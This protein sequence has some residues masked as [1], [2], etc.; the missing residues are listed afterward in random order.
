MYHQQDF[1]V[2]HFNINGGVTKHNMWLTTIQC[3]S[4]SKNGDFW[5]TMVI[6]IT[7]IPRV[8]EISNQWGAES[9][10]KLPCELQFESLSDLSVFSWDRPN[11]I[12]LVASIPHFLVAGLAPS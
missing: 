5:Q 2:I 11:R 6:D 8:L 12:W 3:W 10:N 1:L 7:V 9:P 4:K